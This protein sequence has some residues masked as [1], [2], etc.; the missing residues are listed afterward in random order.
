MRMRGKSTSKYA[1]QSRLG[2]NRGQSYA[3]QTGVHRMVGSNCLVYLPKEKR[4]SIYL[5]STFLAILSPCHLGPAQLNLYEPVSSN[6]NTA[7]SPQPAFPHTI[8][9][10]EVILG[11][12]RNVYMSTLW[13]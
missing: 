3:Q 7:Y 1:L 8:R 5:R 2:Y 10:Q 12:R 13:H 9:G 4:T 6:R 11:S